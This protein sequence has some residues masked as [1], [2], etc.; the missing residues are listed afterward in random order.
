MEKIQREWVLMSSTLEPGRSINVF[1]SYASADKKL[2]DRLEIHLSL[3]QAQG[4]IN[5]W[6]DNQI[7][8][9]QVR[10]QEIDV[11]L[12]TAQVILFLVSPDFM[13]SQYSNGLEMKRAMQKHAANEARVIPIILRPVDWK[14]APFGEL[15]PLPFSGKP[16][17]KWPNRDEA[18]AAIAEGI[19]ALVE[20]MLKE[21]AQGAH[22]PGPSPHSGAAAS[23]VA[24]AAPT[25]ANQFAAAPVAPTALRK[26]MH[27]AYNRSEL[28]IL[29]RDLGISYD[30]LAGE[31][32]EVKI[33]NLIDFFSRRQQYPQLVKKVMAD[34]PDLELL[35]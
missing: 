34:R 9:G 16:V 22:K 31:I 26:A 18:F 5:G 1:I 8:A 20:N 6:S 28:E 7:N 10:L 27:R 3:L 32:L 24:P 17:T 29:C 25:P 35:P 30:D 14:T 2:R 21:G 13:A 23:A 4:L 19:R 33:L 15:Q 12:N 11:H